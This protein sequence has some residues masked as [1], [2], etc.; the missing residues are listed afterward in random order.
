MIDIKPPDESIKK[1]RLEELDNKGRWDYLNEERLNRGHSI[2]NDQK[3]YLYLQLLTDI[4]DTLALIL[5]EM[6]G[7]KH[8][9]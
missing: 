4:S 3:T 5:D 8:D 2:L 7:V 6:R 9:S 1:S